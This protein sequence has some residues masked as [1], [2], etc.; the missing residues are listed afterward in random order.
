LLER[1]CGDASRGFDTHKRRRGFRSTERP[2]V[3]P[4]RL[5]VA[6]KDRRQIAHNACRAIHFVHAARRRWRRGSRMRDLSPPRSSPPPR[7]SRIQRGN[8][9]TPRIDRSLRRTVCSCDS[10]C[11][12]PWSSRRNR[13][14]GEETPFDSEEEL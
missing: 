14:P 12:G 2:V 6:E 3:T 7:L 11:F 9:S 10:D 5:L 1:G 13:I 4:W 8:H